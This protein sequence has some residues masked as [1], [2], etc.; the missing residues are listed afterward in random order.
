MSRFDDC[1]Q[2]VLREEG[3]FVDDPEDRGGATNYG[4]TQRV[5]DVW[6]LAH[7][8]PP[9]PV[10]DILFDEVE[11]IYRANYWDGVHGDSLAPPLDLVMFDT[12]VQHGASRAVMMLQHA[13]GVPAD[14]VLG[15][16]T[17]NAVYNRPASL[18]AQGVMSQRSAYYDAILA[19]DAS[20]ERFR[21]GWNNRMQALAQATSLA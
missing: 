15:P 13:V 1:L 6:N 3:G 8:L 12:A 7:H 11:S 10:R 17:L 4:I 2:F 9:S 18:V 20:Q 14:G 16:V 21:N 19:N 5:Y